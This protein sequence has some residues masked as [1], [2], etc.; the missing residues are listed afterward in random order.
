MLV[1]ES[2]LRLNKNNN[3]SKHDQLVQGVIEAIDEGSLSI[4]DQLPSI[5]KMV[6]EIGFAR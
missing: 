4:G 1:V 5:N 3:L 2:V 6:N